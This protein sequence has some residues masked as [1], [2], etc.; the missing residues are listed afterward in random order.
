MTANRLKIDGK[1]VLKLNIHEF[2]PDDIPFLDSLGIDQLEAD[3]E[4]WRY[5]L[6]HSQADFLATRSA[7][8]EKYK[9]LEEK[10]PKVLLEKI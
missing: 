3:V 6:I 7:I 2:E 5:I 9:V 4:N 8:L 1:P 10:G